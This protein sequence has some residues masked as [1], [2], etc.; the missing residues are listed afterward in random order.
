MY[1]KQTNNLFSMGNLNFYFIMKVVGEI[2]QN[3]Y[4][5]YQMKEKE[6]PFC[7]Q[8]LFTIQSFETAFKNEI[9]CAYKN[10]LIIIN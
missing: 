7:L 2:R 1:Q 9:L 5:F 8:Q 3:C 4:Y 6:V 10:E